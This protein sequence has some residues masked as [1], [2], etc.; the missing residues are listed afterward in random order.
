M[1][2][3]VLEHDKFDLFRSLEWKEIHFTI[4]VLL[5]AVVFKSF[6]G[7]GR[8]SFSRVSNLSYIVFV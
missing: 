8:G 2:N 1:N 6:F 3:F 4:V 5:E 7:H